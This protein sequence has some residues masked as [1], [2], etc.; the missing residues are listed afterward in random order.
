MATRFSVT[1]VL[2]SRSEQDLCSAISVAW[3]AVFGAPATMVSDEESGLHGSYTADF[4][5]RN[6]FQ[7]RF[8]AP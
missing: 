5:E 7:L 3:I 1:H 4:A 8:K 2:A 6:G